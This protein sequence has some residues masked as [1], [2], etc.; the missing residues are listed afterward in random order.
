MIKINR[1]NT[2]SLPGATQIAKKKADLFRYYSK[3]PGKRGQQRFQYDDVKFNETITPIIAAIFKFKCA[4]CES[5]VKLLSSSDNID[6]FRPR[7][8]AKGSNDEYAPDHYWWLSYEWKNI[9]YACQDCIRFRE[10]SFPVAGKRAP[11]KTPYDKIIT[12]EMNLLVDPCNEF[13]EEH[14]TFNIS[15]EAVQCSA[16]GNITIHLFQ[17]NR[18]NLKAA[19]LESVAKLNEVTAQFERAASNDKLSLE[20]R[21]LAIALLQEQLDTIT[22]DTDQPYLG[23]KRACLSDWIRKMVSLDQFLDGNEEMAKMDTNVD[24]LVLLR[25][26]RSL[27][28][29]GFDEIRR[30]LEGSKKVSKKRDLAIIRAL[31]KFFIEKVEVKNFRAIDLVTVQFPDPQSDSLQKKGEIKHH[32]PWLMLLGENGVGKTTFLQALALTLM[33]SVALKKMKIKS[34]DL[35]RYGTEEGY[36]R[37]FLHGLESQ[38]YLTFNAWEKYPK[39]DIDQPPAFLLGYGPIRMMPWGR[40]KPEPVTGKIKVKNLFYP[41]ISLADPCK[42]IEELYKKSRRSPKQRAL[43]DRIGLAVKDLLLLKRNEKLVVENGTALIRYNSKHADRLAQLSE[44]YKSVIALVV[45]IMQVLI[46]GN[47]SMESAK[48][49]ILLDEIGT[50]LHPRWRMQVVKRFRNVFP[51]LQF[52]VTTHDPLCLRGL[53]K[54]E[55]SV[56][57]K[58]NR[59]R[60][61]V[62][63]DLPDSSEYR[64]DQLL[65]S[66]F[67]G[68]NSVIDPDLEKL[69]TEYYALLRKA[70]PNEKQK[71]RIEKLQKQLQPKTHTGSSYREELMYKA[72]DEVIANSNITTPGLAVVSPNGK[73]KT[74]PREIQISKL[75]DEV[76]KE[77]QARTRELWLK[78]KF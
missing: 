74:N 6:Y 24:F 67:F 54:G 30:S 3:S 15:G 52:I 43:F 65:T 48:G 46:R 33:G 45:D 38:L 40:L 68:L 51:K 29:K 61:F 78:Q 44:G 77:V 62:L 13:P 55:I 47:T 11:I 23:F 2:L 72:V 7:R 19:R 60:I 42:W 14:I 41:D 4:Y 21:Q 18:S 31:G 50:H 66:A 22:K 57:D 36:V 16:R 75:T 34:A 49:I 17:L 56:F 58:D 63:T 26:E 64:V 35:L 71:L 8:D 32:E 12:E 69:F 39:C 53:K 5:H 9:Y 70:Q 28:K 37:I 25:K 59:G 1:Q 10:T 27:L 20:K 73:D 76:E